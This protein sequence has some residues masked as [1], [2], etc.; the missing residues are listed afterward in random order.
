[1]ERRPNCFRG[2]RT[3]L[4]LIVAGVVLLLPG[5]Y[6][7]SRDPGSMMTGVTYFLILPVLVGVLI[8]RM[9]VACPHCGGQLFR[10]RFA[11]FLLPA[12]CPLCRKEIR[13]EQDD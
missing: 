4:L 10:G 12:R 5:W 7:R 3:A 8:A 6:F 2:C 1:M 11:R 9:H 13:I